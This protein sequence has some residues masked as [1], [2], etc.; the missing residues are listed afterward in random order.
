MLNK[1]SKIF[2][3][4]LFCNLFLLLTGVGVIAHQLFFTQIDIRIEEIRWIDEFKMEMAEI[5]L[6]NQ[7]CIL[8]INSNGARIIEQNKLQIQKQNLQIGHCTNSQILV[9]LRIKSNIK[10]DGN[11]FFVPQFRAEIKGGENLKANFSL[12]LQADKCQQ[13]QEKIQGN[14]F[15]LC[16]IGIYSGEPGSRESTKTFNITDR[17]KNLLADRIRTM[18]N[19]NNYVLILKIS[20]NLQLIR[21][22][23]S[24]SITIENITPELIIG[25]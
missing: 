7:S 21:D 24:F 23:S 15:V 8:V 25:K 11:L 3:I 16:N 5:E 1:K 13:G 12:Y 4:V 17:R 10:R 2:K 14:G 20:P 6:K 19:R 18:T 9:P 22:L